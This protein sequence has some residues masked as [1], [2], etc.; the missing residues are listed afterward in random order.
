MQPVDVPKDAHPIVVVDN[1]DLQ[2]AGFGRTNL[3]NATRDGLH[4]MYRVSV[5]Y[6]LKNRD[7]R[8]MSG[9]RSLTEG[10]PGAQPS[11]DSQPVEP[12]AAAAAAAPKVDAQPGAVPPQAADIQPAAPA[13][14]TPPVAAAGAELEKA[15]GP[16][17]AMPV[18]PTA[19]NEEDMQG[20]EP[21]GVSTSTE[22]AGV[23]TRS[24][25][26][27]QPTTP[28]TV[29]WKHR[30][31][32]TSRGSPAPATSPIALA[33][34]AT[35]AAPKATQQ[36]TA[37]PAESSPDTNPTRPADVR[38]RTGLGA[39]I[40]ISPQAFQRARSL[41]DDPS[42]ATSFFGLEAIDHV[43]QSLIATLLQVHKLDAHVDVQEVYQALASAFPATHLEDA[44]VLVVELSPTDASPASNAGVL[45]ALVET[46]RDL[47]VFGED[48]EIKFYV[49]V[50][51]DQA[52]HSRIVKLKKGKHANALRW[53]VPC[54]GTYAQHGRNVDLR[55]VSE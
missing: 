45:Q 35:A 10:G 5:C 15:T 8:L 40:T 42:K 23:Q 17:T 32:A 25:R 21:A 7:A 11:A 49:L 33:P 6:R 14:G 3:L 50:V 38:V 52:I 13:V 36:P 44:Q 37:P 16:D 34:P 18:D 43:E 12:A 53:V 31:A 51:A 47:G 28:L 19:A 27:G 26:T 41:F 29:P 48:G 2:R 54:P 39:S 24:R 46:A 9:R 22:T 20:A 30:E 1:L 4:I 55:S